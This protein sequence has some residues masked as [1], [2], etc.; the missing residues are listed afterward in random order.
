MAWAIRHS[1]LPGCIILG[2]MCPCSGAISQLQLEM[3]LRVTLTDVNLSA[4]RL[5]HTWSLELKQFLSV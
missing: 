5:Q 3:L 4:G 2:S 1:F